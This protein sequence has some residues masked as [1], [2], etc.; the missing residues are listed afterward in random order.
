MLNFLKKVFF[1]KKLSKKQKALI[2]FL[3]FLVFLLL[4]K[5]SPAL[6]AW[7]WFTWLPEKIAQAIVGL[8]LVGI[9]NIAQAILNLG[10]I[11]F[12]WSLNGIVVSY[13]DP[14]K[15]PVISA[16]WTLIRDIT[17]IA[18]ILGLVYI[19]LATALRFANF[20]VKKAFPWFLIMALLV[21]FTPVICGIVVDVANLIMNFFLGGPGNWEILNSVYDN[22][23]GL[24]LQYLTGEANWVLYGK[25]AILAV[26]GFVGGL[27]FLLFGLLFFVRYFAIWILVILSPLAFFAFIFPQTKRWFN[28]WLNQLIQWSF[29]GAIAGFF[30]YLAQYTLLLAQT[31]RLA[32]A[33][34][35]ESAFNQLGPYLAALLFTGI[36]FYTAT[37]T[38]A[39]FSNYVIATGK[40][41][42]KGAAGVVW[43]GGKVAAKG[44]KEGARRVGRKTIG[45]DRL[46]KMAREGITRW[47]EGEKGAK[48]WF[49][50]RTAGLVN[51]VVRKGAGA[52]IKVEK[53]KKDISKA[54]QQL[55]GKGSDFQIARI[56]DELGNPLS[57]VVPEKAIGYLQAA[58]E[59]GTL[60]D[61]IQKKQFTKEEIERIK[62]LALLN[63]K[64]HDQKGL[65]QSM[66][67]LTAPE[68]KPELWAKGQHLIDEG[69]RSLENI[70]RRL[71]VGVPLSELEEELKAALATINEG[72]EIQAQAVKEIISGIKRSDIKNL[73]ESA[74]TNPVV[75][76]AIVD[77]FSAGQMAEIGR[78]FGRH[79]VNGIQAEINS[80]DFRKLAKTNPSLAFWL[81]TNAAQNQGFSVPPE[82]RGLTRQELR[83]TI[84]D[85]RVEIE[86]DR[87]NQK[88]LL[89]SQGSLLLRTFYRKD[90]PSET[91]QL[92]KE[93]AVEQGKTLP[94][95][96]EIEKLIKKEEKAF[97][98]LS[99][100]VRKLYETT[101]S[102][103]EMRDKI[104]AIPD[105]PPQTLQE[106]E[107]K[108]Q[109]A[110]RK[111]ITTLEEINA[112]QGKLLAQEKEKLRKLW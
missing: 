88:R 33:N 48:G 38:N 69:N 108:F 45:E 32:L 73:S 23:K 98:N 47:G 22:Q 93:L 17:N 100:T 97:D 4:L 71:A 90:T 35:T 106:A 7:G 27:I 19:G 20:D 16:G 40:A 42:G 89:A 104:K 49:K 60:A 107:R 92:I 101:R 66:P 94:T 76:K 83:T 63:Y 24:I 112:Q 75:K 96:E 13:T 91:K 51:Y 74:L 64:R 111:F 86:K 109:E 82:V 57:F 95:E 29:I 44:M 59:D 37:T 31:N 80:R 11:F 81:T 58:L 99:E 72:K 62:N 61:A 39:M 65:A 103:K 30:L 8:F 26:F 34:T 3:F 14:G 87:A 15:N 41:I 54:K 56:K 78:N 105:V 10:I 36:G 21:N 5:S 55:K 53:E 2:V 84:L 79:I 46:Q 28:T 50:R 43:K 102:A 52:I 70:E 110:K 12:N 67:D 6:A 9:L 77:S 18:F 85:A 25:I 1:P 68:L